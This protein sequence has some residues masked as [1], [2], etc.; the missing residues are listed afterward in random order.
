MV[1]VNTIVIILQQRMNSDKN[2]FKKKAYSNVIKQLLEDDFKDKNIKS[3][4]DFKEIKGVG[5]S[6]HKLIQDIIDG[7]IKLDVEEEKKQNAIQMF[8]NIMS[9]GIVKAK[10]LVEENNIYTI[11]ELKNNQ[12]L[13]NKKQI[14]G[15]N[16]YDDFNKK[17]PREEM[18]VHHA[19][20]E[21]HLRDIDKNIIFN[22]V[23]SYRRGNESSG[24]IDV[25]VSH[26]SNPS[27][28]LKK[29]VEKFRGQKYIVDDFAFGKEKYMG[30]CKVCS[31][32]RRIDIL[33]IPPSQY[34]YALL[35]FTGSKIFNINMRK[36]ALEKGYS[37]SEHGMKN[38][39]TE[40]MVTQEMKTEKDVFKF[41]TMEYVEPENR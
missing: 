33:F 30:V 7:V 35:Y 2:S 12:H 11:L 19:M 31:I 39:K 4:E 34:P 10:K 20:I 40:Q 27:D 15:L 29:I 14:I 32:N 1:S 17:I 23:G 3:M 36:I 22:I 16:Y 26:N 5:K 25:L 9:I 37:L 24:D 28:L 21:K 8:M 18:N 6:I 38:M 13:L 41:L